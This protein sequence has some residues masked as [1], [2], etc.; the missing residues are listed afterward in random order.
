[1]QLIDDASKI[2][3]RLWSVRLA[4]LA[5]VLGAIDAALP[6]VAPAHASPW[7]ALLTMFVSLA[8]AGARMVRQPSVRSGSDG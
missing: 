2:W 5:A 8:A 4:I 1:M 3:H 7:F 6:F